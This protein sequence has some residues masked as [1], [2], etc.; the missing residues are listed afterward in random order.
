MKGHIKIGIIGAGRVG[1]TLAIV[2]KRNN[3][4]VRIASRSRMSAERAAKISGVNATSIE[5]AVENSDFI[6]LSVPD[7]EIVNIA[8]KI[9]PIVKN[10]QVIAHLS[11]A[12]PSSVINFLNAETMSIHPLKSFTNPEVAADTISGTLF[13]VEGNKKALAKVEK[14]VKAIG[15]KFI[16]IKTEDKPLYHIA[17]VL[18]SNYPVTL[19]HIAKLIFTSIGFSKDNSTKALLNLLAGTMKNIETVGTPNALTGPIERG[20]ISTIQIHLEAIEDPFLLSIYKTV[21]SATLNVAEEKG[22]DKKKVNEIKELF[23]E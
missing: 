8:T 21:G 23:N 12:I 10:E 20:D 18:V 3:F 2:L 14:I 19:F 22:L 4:K 9:A 16:V 15:G 7:A 5:E 13:A 1:S 17:A 6:F 11:G